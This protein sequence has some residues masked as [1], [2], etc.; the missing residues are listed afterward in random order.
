MDDLLHHEQDQHREAAQY[1]VKAAYH[2]AK[3]RQAGARTRKAR[4]GART[5]SRRS[6]SSR[7]RRRPTERA[8]RSARSQA[9]MAAE[10]AYRALDEELKAKFDYDTGHH[11]YAGVIDKVK[12]TFEK[13][14]TKAN[15]V[16]F[17]ELQTVIDDVRV[18][19]SGRSRLARARARSTTRVAPASTTRAPPAAQALHRQGREAAQAGR[20]RASDDDLHPSRPTRSASGAAKSGAPRASVRSTTPTRR[21]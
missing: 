7:L 1:V 18:A 10:C 11:R 3:I 13:D 21:W 5:P 2:A 16:W 6:T 12:E 20:D 4:S 17:T 15:D 9:D 14:M 8:A 19:R